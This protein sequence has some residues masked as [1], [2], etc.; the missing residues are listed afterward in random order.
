MKKLII[1]S[2]F[3]VLLSCHSKLNE[4]LNGC[5]RLEFN[6]EKRY[7]NIRCGALQGT[8]DDCIKR[9]C[10]DNLPEDEKWYCSALCRDLRRDK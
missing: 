8:L 9:I 7:C 4:C 1:L 10:G 6:Y 3:P 5:S 2:L